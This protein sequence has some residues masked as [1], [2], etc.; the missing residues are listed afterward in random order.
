MPD[1]ILIT[2]GAG[3]VGSTIAFE[4]RRVFPGAKVIALDNLRRRGSELNVGRLQSAG[5]QF[6]HG[7]VREPR[8]LEGLA[9]D[10]IVECSAEPS[11]Q[12]GYS[13][14]PDYVVQTN[15]FG[16]Y[17]CLNLAR[18]SRAD[19][20]F[21]STSRVYSAESLNALA[22]RETETRFEW[23]DDQP[24]PGAGGAGI[25][26]EFPTKG[27]RSIYGATKLAAEFMIEE[28]AAA[29]GFR[30]VINRCGLIA[31]PWQMGKADQGVVTHWLAAHHFKRPLQYIGFG[32]E[33]KQVR[34]ILHVQDVAELVAKQSQ[35]MAGFH[36]RT[37][38]VGGGLPYS[39]SLCEM[40]AQCEE[41]TGQCLRI[42]SNLAE[43][44]ADIRC[45]VT[46]TSRIQARH[47]WRPSRSP[48]VVLRDT[49]RWLKENEDRVGSALFAA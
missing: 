18:L 36:R 19:F 15:L 6:V 45:Y 47:D 4:M 42:G 1:R 11:A 44:P 9:A 41:L 8:D 5:V 16:C 12:A 24:L 37:L 30:Y 17:H 48:A 43:R 46:D 39:L 33:G 13:T 14:E 7:D 29:Y 2:G 34:D 26:E 21:L 22:F 32:G 49:L 31:G 35:S 40:T 23:L 10:L 25:S 20:V 27:V 3:F 28:Y 38:N